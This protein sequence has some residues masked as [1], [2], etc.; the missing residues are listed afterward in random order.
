MSVQLNLQDE[1]EDEIIWTLEAWGQYSATSAY[2]IQ[3]AG[4]VTSS[5]PT[6]IWKAWVPPRCKM[7]LWLLLQDRL[8]TAASWM[9]NNYFCALCERNL[10]TAVHL[11]IGCPF[12]WEIWC[13]VSTW[14]R[15]RNLHPAQW[16]SEHDME[17]WFY[18]MTTKGTEMAH[19]TSIQTLRCIWKQR[20][21]MIFRDSRRPAQA[22]FAEIRDEC[23]TWSMAG[24][25]I[26]NP[27]FGRNVISE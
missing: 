20:N 16:T 1:Q 17:D 25:K 12:S 7:F 15:C 18:S 4:Q 3:F 24:G 14:S 21:A 9:E 5:F 2:N 26:L 13:L 8:W 27:L 23:L 22:V 6:L 11:F 10:E 19:T